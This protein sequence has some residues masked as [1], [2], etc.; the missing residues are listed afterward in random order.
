[1]SFSFFK[2]KNPG[3]GEKFENRVKKA[4]SK[5]RG[6]KFPSFDRSQNSGGKK[7]VK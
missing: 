6:M 7:A 2:P 4:I 3:K 5:A 1:M